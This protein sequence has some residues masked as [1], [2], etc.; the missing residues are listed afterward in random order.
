MPTAGP[1]FW[2]AFMMALPCTQYMVA[3]STTTHCRLDTGLEATTEGLP[4]FLSWRLSV[5]LLVVPARVADV[6]NTS[7][8]STAMLAPGWNAM[9]VPEYRS[10][11]TPPRLG[12]RCR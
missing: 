4:P 7:V 1:P 3:S 12:M 9:P 2:L 6:Q 5:L 8:A 10:T 11:V